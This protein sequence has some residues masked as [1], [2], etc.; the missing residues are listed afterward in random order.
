MNYKLEKQKWKNY[1]KDIKKNKKYIRKYG[2]VNFIKMKYLER[3]YKDFDINNP[4]TFSEKLQARRL[5]YNE[6]MKIC[7]DKDKVRKYVES[8]IGSK[9]LIPQYFC[10]TKIT[11]NDIEKLPNSFILKTSNGSGT[12]ILVKDKTKEQIKEIVKLINFY[13]KIEYGYIWGEF[14]HNEIPITIVA[15]KLILDKNGNVPNDLKVHC[16][17]NGSEK[18]KVIEYH[19]KVDGKNYK[20]MY[21]ENW[22]P[23]DYVF[24]FKSDGRKIK[25]PKN[26]KEILNVCDKL[27]ED[28]NYVRVD[29]YNLD[30][31]IYFGE[32]TFIPGAGYSPFEPESANTLWGRY[33]G[34][35]K[36]YK[37]DAV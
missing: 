35:E 32:L 6:L 33:M 4:I 5:N 2:K 36:E 10:K 29:L 11:K 20:N 14:H 3:G 1:L 8:K 17:D 23:L 34:N 26:L 37:K 13:T 16:F 24:G 21:D 12:N 30:G 15:E 7:A 22:N 31:K 19:Y 27:S 18:H 25:K 28:T 9:Y